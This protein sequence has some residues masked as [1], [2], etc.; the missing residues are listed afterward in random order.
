[1]LPETV[2]ASPAKLFFSTSS[3]QSLFGVPFSFYFYPLTPLFLAA[4]MSIR[5]N[6]WTPAE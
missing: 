1:M 3:C 4:A 2:S 5:Q 6:Y